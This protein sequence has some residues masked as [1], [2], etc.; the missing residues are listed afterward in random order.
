MGP[1]GEVVTEV[2]ERVLD[3]PEDLVIGQ[4]D[5]FV[6]EA[7]EEAFGLAAEGLEELLAAFFTPLRG[8]GRS[9]SGLVQHGDRPGVRSKGV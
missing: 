4:V 2:A 5:E 6:G 7:L 9:R 1:G 8:R 3:G